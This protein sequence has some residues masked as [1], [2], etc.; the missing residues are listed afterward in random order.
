MRN[1]AQK[2][3]NHH[4][5]FDHDEENNSRLKYEILYVDKFFC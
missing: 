3:K 5:L 2:K 1:I 4:V